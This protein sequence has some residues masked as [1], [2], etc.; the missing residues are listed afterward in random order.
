MWRSRLK[1]P[2]SPHVLCTAWTLRP[3]R[4]SHSCQSV[5]TSMWGSIGCGHSGCARQM[6]CR[7]A[8]HWKRVRFGAEACSHLAA[9]APAGTSAR[10]SPNPRAQSRWPA[11]TVRHPVRRMDV[12]CGI[13]VSF[14]SST[15]S[16][17]T[18]VF[19]SGWEPVR[20][21]GFRDFPAGETWG[22][23]P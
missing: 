21:A 16:L 3:R 13:G 17:Q 23:R 22:Q 8:R 4:P 2:H 6:Q 11:W 12:I 1:P 10:C 5:R 9:L 7:P 14:T 19:G 15:D 18:L 20:S